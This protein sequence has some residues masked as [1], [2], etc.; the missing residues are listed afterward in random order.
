MSLTTA[1]VV[2]DV[3]QALCSGP[4]KTFESDRVIAT[5][6]RVTDKARADGIPVFFV[7]HETETGL[8]V[9]GSAGWQLAEGLHQSEED[10]Y[11]SKRFSDAFKETE[12]QR[13]C[14]DQGI[15]HLIICGMQSE[16]C[17]DSTT[18]HALARG[19]EVTIIAD[20]HTT[21]DTSVLPAEKISAHHNAT[22]QNL[23][24]YQNTAQVVHAS[25]LEI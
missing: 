20:G 6:N 18:R 21:I 9:K 15:G 3:Q 14:D 1:V 25:E 22:W 19:F 17:V 4:F 23:T 24:S 11:I 13:Y 16:F 5:I 7:Q 10:A 12:L 8:M 2:I